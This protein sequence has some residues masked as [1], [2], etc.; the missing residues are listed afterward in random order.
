[1]SDYRYL[2]VVDTAKLLR[3]ALKKAFPGVKFSVRSSSYSGGASIRVAWKDGP[4][5]KA[6]E[7]V[8]KGYEGA[9][10]DG[11]IDMKNYKS[12]WLLP[13][14]SVAS[15]SHDPGTVGS[16]GMIPPED[17]PK[18]HPDA[19]A[20]HFGADFVFCERGRSE[21][22]EA[23]AVAWL[24]KNYDPDWAPDKWYNGDYG[25]SLVWKVC[26]RLYPFTDEN[27]DDLPVAA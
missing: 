18:P 19:E 4:L 23:A 5:E 1:V 20:V 8:A 21:A 26:E 13:D 11:M 2:S 12:H 6:V 16:A 10:F 25:R 14:G 7:R 24:K 27:Y 3:V 15:V 17:N 22:L 9:N